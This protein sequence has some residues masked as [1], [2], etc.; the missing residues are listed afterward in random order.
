MSIQLRQCAAKL[1]PATYAR[2]QEFVE[3][4][5]PFC[6]G[7]SAAIRILL[8]VLFALEGKGTVRLDLDSIR[9][10]LDTRI[11]RKP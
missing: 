5:Y 9:Q 8:Q 10:I 7:Y 1:D 11:K 4:S 6:S 2:L 3:T